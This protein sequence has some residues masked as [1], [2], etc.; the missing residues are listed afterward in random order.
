MVIATSAV[1]FAYAVA[2]F[3][4]VDSACGATTNRARGTTT[5]S[6]DDAGE[7]DAELAKS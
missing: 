7:A 3:T 4:V 5:S 2:G 6:C 1:T